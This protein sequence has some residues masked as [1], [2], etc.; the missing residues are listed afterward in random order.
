MFARNANSSRS[1]AL[2]SAAAAETLPISS[3]GRRYKQFILLKI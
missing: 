2:W 1:R 3:F